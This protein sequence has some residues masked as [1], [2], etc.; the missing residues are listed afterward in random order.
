[1][2]KLQILTELKVNS[3]TRVLRRWLKVTELEMLALSETKITDAGLKDIAKLQ[4]LT[5]LDLDKT[6]SPTR[7][8][9]ELA[10]LQ[11]LKRLELDYTKITDAGIKQVAK[12]QN[13]TGPSVALQHKIT[14]AGVAELK[15]A[16]PKCSI[17]GPP[18][19]ITPPKPLSSP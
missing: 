17:L 13:L 9:K 3:R 8:P 16:L 10:K 14:D 6:K 15:K 7:L 5:K 2:V 12:L 11:Q 18:P 19:L 4:K 1:M